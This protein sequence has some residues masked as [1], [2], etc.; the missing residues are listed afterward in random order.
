MASTHKSSSNNSKASSRKLSAKHGLGKV[1]DLADTG[2]GIV[3]RFAQS[4]DKVA[5]TVNKVA[6]SVIDETSK[7]VDAHLD[8]HKD[9]FK[10]PDL[11]DVP[12]AEAQEILDTY[13]FKYSLI[14]VA[15]DPQ[16]AKVQPDRIL[17]MTPKAKATVAPNRFTFVKASTPTV[18]RLPPASNSSLIRRMPKSLRRQQPSRRKSAQKRPGRSSKPRIRLPNKW[19]ATPAMSIWF[20]R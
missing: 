18:R 13:H 10:M 19:P 4:V 2:L 1:A 12:L 14:K 11:I 17:S 7:V 15:A 5:D 20:Q 6:P 3:D 16:Y 9:D 8:K